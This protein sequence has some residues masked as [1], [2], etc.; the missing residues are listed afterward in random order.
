[1]M[2]RVINIAMVLILLCVITG[3]K[4]N[5]SVGENEKISKDQSDKL[6]IVEKIDPAKISILG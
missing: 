6:K 1:M 4:R 5:V 3:C 2:K